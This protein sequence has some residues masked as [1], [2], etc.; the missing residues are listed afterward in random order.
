[1]NP[2]VMLTGASGFV[3]LHY[4]SERP[5]RLTTTAQSRARS[6]AAFTLIELIVVMTVIAIL[7]AMLLPAIRSGRQSAR[8]QTTRALLA[9]IGVALEQFRNANGEFPPERQSTSL[10]SSECLVVYLAS[11]QTGRNFL[12]LKKLIL[13][14]VNTNRYQEVVD[15]WGQPLVYNRP[16]Y[17]PPDTNLADDKPPIHNP[18]TYDLFSVGPLST[19]IPA[20]ALPTVPLDTYE[21][22]AVESG[23][24]VYL[25]ESTGLS[26]GGKNEYVGNW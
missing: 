9:Q 22:N 8:T 20:F 5:M 13:S 12:S 17:V 16:Q 24:D 7:A 3:V 25:R 4:K 14:D 10:V 23:G 1:M 21:S 11:T 2:R 19:Q 6:Q 26:G 18:K 15:A